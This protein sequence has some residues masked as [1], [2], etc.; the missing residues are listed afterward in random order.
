M[1]NDIPYSEVI[2]L[3]R[4]QGLTLAGISRDLRLPYWRVRYALISGRSYTICSRIA[5]LIGD[6][7]AVDLWPSRFSLARVEDNLAAA[8]ERAQASTEYRV[9]DPPTRQTKG[10]RGD[11]RAETR[12]FFVTA[13]GSP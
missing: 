3:I 13:E 4:A 10:H 11:E 2:R 8:E 7:S 1:N 12:Q 6:R 5:V 9:P